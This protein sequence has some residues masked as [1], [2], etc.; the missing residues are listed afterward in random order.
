M[1]AHKNMCDVR[2]S[3]NASYWDEMLQLN[4]SADSLNSLS[5]MQ[6]SK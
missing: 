5:L 3:I 1:K 2:Q 4:P 6:G